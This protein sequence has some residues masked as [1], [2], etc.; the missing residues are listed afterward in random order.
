MQFLV[1]LLLTLTS[2]VLDVNCANVPR[3]KISASRRLG[4]LMVPRTLQERAAKIEEGLTLDYEL[5]KRTGSCG[6]TEEACVDGGCCPDGYY[7]SN[8]FTPES[9][10]CLNG[11]ICDG[12]PFF[13]PLISRL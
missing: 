8:P 12:Q 10:C 4:H 3:T 1:I 7:C 13:L 9:G 6:A 5:I 11:Q 2:L